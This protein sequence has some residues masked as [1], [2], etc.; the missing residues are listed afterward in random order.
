MYIYIYIYIYICMYE[1]FFY[2]SDVALKYIERMVE[3]GTDILPV[4]TILFHAL[5]N[6]MKRNLS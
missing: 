6:S 4:N 3:N 1:I 2:R 5:L